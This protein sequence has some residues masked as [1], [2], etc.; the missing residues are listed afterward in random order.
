[1]WSCAFRSGAS[2]GGCGLV[3]VLV[4]V[5]ALDLS[6]LNSDGD[7]RDV[8]VLVALLALPTLSHPSSFLCWYWKEIGGKFTKYS[9]TAANAPAIKPVTSTP[10]SKGGKGGRSN[11]NPNGSFGGDSDDVGAPTPPL[12]LDQ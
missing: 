3:V 6:P 4:I 5:L 11:S 12:R 1:M 7:A 10:S 2:W 9:T 8:A